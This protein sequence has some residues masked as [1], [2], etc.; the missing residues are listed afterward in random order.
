MHMLHFNTVL[1]FC[2]LLSCFK[3]IIHIPMTLQKWEEPDSIKGLLAAIKKNVWS[4][5]KTVC[6]WEYLL[7]FL[8]WIL[9]QPE[10]TRGCIYQTCSQFPVV[11]VKSQVFKVQVKSE[12]K[13]LFYF[14]QYFFFSGSCYCRLIN[15][16]LKQQNRLFLL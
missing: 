13:S 3:I 6:V 12:V 2:I 10:Y 1:C 5:L 11:Q 8:F 16:V 9:A 15:S 14:Q 4:V 7:Y